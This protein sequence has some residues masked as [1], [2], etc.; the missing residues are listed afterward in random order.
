M[1]AFVF[2]VFPDVAASTFRHYPARLKSV[3]LIA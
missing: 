3:Q 1:R 2:A